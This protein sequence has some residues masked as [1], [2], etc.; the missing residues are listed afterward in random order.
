MT[1][2][3]YP[4]PPMAL[5]VEWEMW[6]ELAITWMVRQPSDWTADDLRAAMP[7]CRT[8]WPGAAVRTARA[9]G[10]ITTTGK[11]TRS[12]AKSRKGSLLPYWTATGKAAA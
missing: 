9:R 10:L 7:E 6:R 11:V 8:N 2:F 5:A 4:D 1:T 12:A 3:P